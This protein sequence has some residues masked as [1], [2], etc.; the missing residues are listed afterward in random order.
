MLRV[1]L[2][3]AFI[4]VFAGA[5]YASGKQMGVWEPV[6]P[7]PP[8]AQAPLVDSENDERKK[9]SGSSA[10]KKRWIR[11]AN[12]LCRRAERETRRLKWP[13]TTERAQS[14]I[15]K[16]G[17]INARYQDAFASLKPVKADRAKFV[18]VL[19]LFEKDERLIDEYVS[20]L[21]NQQAPRS[22]LD[23]LSRLSAT[24]DRESTLLD[25][26]G[27]KDCMAGF[28]VPYY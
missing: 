13:T 23:V 9:K 12:A 22:F 18:K 20:A 17:S 7:P 3:L 15:E 28:A 26:L 10:A 14:L 21:R 8:S 1:V 19:A 16:L 5:I 27:A 24:A 11:G 2:V 25:E 6:D 4:G